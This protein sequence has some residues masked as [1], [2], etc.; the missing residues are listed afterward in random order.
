MAPVGSPASDEVADLTPSWA[1]VEAASGDVPA[2][3][4]PPPVVATDDEDEVDER[5]LRPRHPYTWLHLLVLAL[6]AFV[7]GFLVMLLVIN[8]RSDNG[9]APVHADHSTSAAARAGSST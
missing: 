2:P 6:V 3:W 1:P 5:E 4:S 8:G 9:A 7:L